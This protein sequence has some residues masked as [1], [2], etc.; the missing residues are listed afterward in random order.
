MDA[1]LPEAQLPIRMAAFGHCFRTEAGAG[2]AAGRGLYRVHQFSKVELF[3]LSTPET[4]DALHAELLELEVG[5]YSDLGLH[6]KVGPGVERGNM[7]R[8]SPARVSCPAW[9]SCTA[10]RQRLV[11]SAA[12]L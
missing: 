3:V 5:I 4:S 11:S 1:I 9:P 10:C 7:L 12:A 6:F 8:M 2:G